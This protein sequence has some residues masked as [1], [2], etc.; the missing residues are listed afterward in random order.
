[1]LRIAPR[2]AIPELEWRRVANNGIHT[3]AYGFDAAGPQAFVVY[4]IGGALVEI[5]SGGL[6][7]KSPGFYSPGRLTLDRSKP[8]PRAGSRVL[9]LQAQG[10]SVSPYPTDVTILPRHVLLRAHAG[11][12]GREVGCSDTIRFDVRLPVPLG[13][14]R[15]W[16]AVRLPL[17]ELTRP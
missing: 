2:A 14:R 17:K 4:G 7:A 3:L 15:I 12:S 13:H 10:C 1:M 6:C 5:G 9:H 11:G 8:A 16:N